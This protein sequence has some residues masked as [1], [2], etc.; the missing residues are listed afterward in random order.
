MT[1]PRTTKVETPVRIEVVDA[2]R[3]L[4]ELAAG[5]A[6]DRPDATGRGVDLVRSHHRLRDFRSQAIGWR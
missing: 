4:E 1:T 6:A 5:S 2:R 3:M